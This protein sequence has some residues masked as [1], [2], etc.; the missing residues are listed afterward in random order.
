MES[1][2]GGREEG[3]GEGEFLNHQIIT[4]VINYNSVG[5]WTQRPRQ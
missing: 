5:P 1:R 2:Q 4:L 3:V